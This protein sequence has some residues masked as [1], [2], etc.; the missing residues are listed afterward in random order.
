MKITEKEII[1]FIK[2]EGANCLFYLIFFMSLWV[3]F[4]YL[5]D[6]NEWIRWKWGYFNISLIPVFILA[7]YWEYLNIKGRLRRLE[8][9]L[10]K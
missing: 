1:K 9:E 4:P 8:E 6:K 3:L 7:G 5:I 10:S 2:E